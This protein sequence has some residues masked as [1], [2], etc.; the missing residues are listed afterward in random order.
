MKALITL[1]TALLM[2]LPLMATEPTHRVEPP[3]W[4]VGMRDTSLQ[5][6]LHAPGIA[7][8]KPTLAPYPGVTLKS[9]HRASSA[10]Y[11]FVDLD[12]APGTKPGELTLNVAGKAL[13]YPLLAR[14][15]GSADRQGFGPKDAI[16]LVVPDR[17]AQGGS[18]KQADM[19][20]G[21]DRADHGGRHG[22]DL[23]G[24]RQHLGYIAGLGFTQVWPTPLVEN[25]SAKYSYH[26][27]AA[28]DFYKIDP[29]FGTNDDF[30]AFVSEARSK[31]IG[32]IQDIVLNHIG[33]DHWWMKD[34]PAPDWVNAWPQYTE[35]H[36]ARMTLQDPYASAQDRKRFTDGWFVP[37]MPDLNQR[38]PELA[39][40]LIQK[41][42]WWVERFGLSGIRTDTYSYSDRDFLSRWSARVMQEYPRLNI[43]GEEWSPHPAVVA[44]WQ[45]GKKNH[46]GYISH[47]PSM[48]D[49]PMQS[50]L[51]A[52]LTE[53]D[54][55]HTGLTKL[56]EGLAHDFVY[57]DPSN[58]VLFDGN[59]D[60][61]R[62]FSLL[63][64]DVDLTKIA[65]AYL[66]TTRRIPQ[67]FYGSELLLQSPTERD[68]GKVR[69]D[70]P[71]GWP[72]D[73]V[74]AFT[75]AGLTAEQRDMQDW[76][77]RLFTWRKTATVIHD[78]A[79]MQFAPLEGVYVFFR[80]D[81]GRTVLVALNK[82]GKAVELPVAR[83]A[84]RVAPG[85]RAR[86]ALSGKDLTLG[87]SLSVPARSPLILEI[88]R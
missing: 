50:N 22:G 30:G 79:L 18:G 11:L 33:S 80:Y 4:W 8:A 61:P 88:G 40:Y 63:K 77:R 45:R 65:L 83:F 41:T 36:H 56:Y 81:A 23:A 48:M 76:V 53:G 43:V 16:Y 26:G 49:F 34:L 86:D 73:K 38:R 69:A 1:A 68:D 31:G 58:L 19:K 3:N 57:P 55:P 28:T 2:S 70:M 72:G 15:P 39:T 87:A 46:D 13:R 14:A 10:N 75:G 74:N 78:G 20:E 25:N 9:S 32:V 82:T 24:M 42:L 5:L 29:R 37:G 84:E 71:G 7:N 6:M 60:T 44:Y 27:Y 35:T 64:N 59:H 85:Q 54:G 12:I 67:L 21:Q 52:A 62:I 47:A 66:A 51:L 17:F